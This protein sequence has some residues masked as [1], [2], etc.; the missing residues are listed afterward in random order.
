MIKTI[1]SVLLRVCLRTVVSLWLVSLCL[2]QGVPPIRPLPFPDARVNGPTD[3]AQGNL[4]MGWPAE[5]QLGYVQGWLEGAYW[6]YFNACTKAHV[7]AP[8]VP[9]LQDKCLANIPA[10]NLTS[11]AY[12]AQVTEFY[13]KYPHD[14]ALPIRRLLRKLLEP[15]MTVD[16]VHKWLDELI[17]SARRSAAK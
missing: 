15:C 17:E 14:R 11:E 9:H 10:P 3:I 8:S 5:H 1:R 2:S 13:S 7:A 6:G 4:W 12:L 16:G